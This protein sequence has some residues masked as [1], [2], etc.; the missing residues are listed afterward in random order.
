[1]FPLRGF[2]SDITFADLGDFE[3]HAFL[4]EN[5]CAMEMEKWGSP[6]F[7]IWVPWAW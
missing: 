4:K 3:A 1:M 2:L 6:F 7:G 5:N